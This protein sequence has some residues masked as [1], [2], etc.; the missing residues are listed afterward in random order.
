MHNFYTKVDFYP[1]IPNKAF[2][3]TFV[4]ISM[5]IGKSTRFFC[6]GNSVFYSIEKINFLLN[7]NKTMEAT[8]HRSK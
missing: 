6:G 7:K 8:P 5:K 1:I 4:S 2:L 3:H